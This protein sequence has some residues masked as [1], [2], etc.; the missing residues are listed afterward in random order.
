[1]PVPE[2]FHIRPYQASDL[3]RL[4]E[5]TT[6]T[7][8]EVSIDNNMERKFGRFGYGDWRTRKAASIAVDCNMQPD[9]VF[10]MVEGEAKAVGYITTRLNTSSGIG[11]IPNL[12]IDPAYQSRG[13]GRALLEH[14]LVFFRDQGMQVANIET[15][16]QNPIGKN[17][18]P[19]LGFEEVAHQIHYAMRL[20]P[21]ED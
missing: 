11:W 17:L 8:S 10:V 13:L 5:I 21:K 19:S 20:K 2:G 18:Y 4:Q 9:G 7:F 12:A 1:M 16:E 14:A 15:L 3:L 6:Q